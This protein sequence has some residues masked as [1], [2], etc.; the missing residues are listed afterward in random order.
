[1]SYGGAF[2]YI[3]RT[4]VLPMKRLFILNTH[5]PPPPPGFV[6]EI[7]FALLFADKISV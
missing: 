1:L 7:T 4:V 3:M 5:T 2:D 6:F